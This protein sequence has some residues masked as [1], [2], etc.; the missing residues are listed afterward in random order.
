MFINYTLDDHDT[1]LPTRCNAITTHE[2]T[3]H[4]LCSDHRLLDFHPV[5]GGGLSIRAAHGDVSIEIS[6]ISL[7]TTLMSLLLLLA[8]LATEVDSLTPLPSLNTKEEKNSLN[9]DNSPFPRN[10]SMFK[11]TVVY[12]GDIK[13]RESKNES[14]HDT[15]EQK[16]VAPDVEHP[17]GKVAL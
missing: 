1:K 16:A 9:K 5:V 13:N 14:G 2:K 11:H 4:L 6:K 10:S 15:P 12:D 7:L 8:C 3:F 17:L